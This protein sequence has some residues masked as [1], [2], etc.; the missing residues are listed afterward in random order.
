MALAVTAVFVCGLLAHGIATPARATVCANAD[1]KLGSLSIDQLRASVTCLVNADRRAHGLRA[2]S[3]N[4]KLYRAAKYHNADMQQKLHELTHQSSNGE[5][6]TKRIRRFGYTKGY[7][8]W[9][10]GEILGE[11]WGSTTPAGVLDAWR[12]SPSH[13]RIIRTGKYRHFGVAAAQGTA[14]NTSRPGGLFTVDF[15][16]RA[17]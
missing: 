14:S 5:S 17:S 9:A 3:S 2:L 16:F 11:G 4:A 7:R 12:Q 15:G 8:R 13:L 6:S 10:V 1:E